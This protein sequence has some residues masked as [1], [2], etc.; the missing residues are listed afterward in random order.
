[1]THKMI[2]FY[3]FGY[4]MNGRILLLFKSSLILLFQTIELLLEWF[5]HFLRMFFTY[6]LTLF[7][8]LSGHLLFFLIFVFLR[9]VSSKIQYLFLFFFSLEYAKG[10]LHPGPYFLKTLC[11]FLKNKATSDKVSNGSD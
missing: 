9:N 6:H 11:S 2:N 10:V 7:S 5:Y 8:S 4:Q 1:M 3:F